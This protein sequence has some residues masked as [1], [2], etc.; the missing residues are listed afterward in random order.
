MNQDN[1]GESEGSKEQAS[2]WE[3]AL[4]WLGYVNNVLLLPMFTIL[5]LEAMQTQ[6]VEYFDTIN[7]FFCA[8]FFS[9]W[10]LGL[11]LADN[12]MSYLRKP[13]NIA[14]V[15][16]SIPF[17][18]FAQGLRVVRLLRLL[19]IFRLAMR[20]RRF[21]GKSAKA[22]RAFG[23]F[24]A[25]VMTGA[26]AFRIVEPQTTSGLDEALWWS[27]VTLS[28]VGYGDITPTTS[29]GHMVAAFVIF[30]GVGVFGY[31][32]GFMTSILEDPEEDEILDT[33]RRLE[34]QLATLQTTLESS[35]PNTKD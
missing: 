33:V 13:E 12:R 16:S 29:S 28:T 19:R 23:F 7:H 22:V 32:A 34:L 24:G 35:L 25:L 14:D 18:A 21:K 1:I 17:T 31:M 9:E 15:V 4:G 11:L 5:V 26:L 10:L 2:I 27:I 6:S 20:L 8:M 3:R 30:A